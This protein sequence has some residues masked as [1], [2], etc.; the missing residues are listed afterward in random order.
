MRIQTQKHD[1][2]LARF[3]SAHLQ[4]LTMR[5]VTNSHACRRLKPL[6]VYQR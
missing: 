3:L 6:Q 1:P 2:A 5:R 4:L